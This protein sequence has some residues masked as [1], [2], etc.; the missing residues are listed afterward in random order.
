L[1]LYI[2]APVTKLSGLGIGNS[3]AGKTILFG[4]GFNYPPRITVTISTHYRYAIF[5]I[6]QRHSAISKFMTQRRGHW[7][8]QVDIDVK[9]Y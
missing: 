4:T 1:S 6:K 3:S 2:N 5:P 7:H 8:R 9:G